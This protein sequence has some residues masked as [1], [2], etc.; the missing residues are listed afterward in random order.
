MCKLCLFILNVVHTS[1]ILFP[2]QL[3]AAE[4]R[5]YSC[6]VSPERIPVFILQHQSAIG[7]SSELLKTNIPEPK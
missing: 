5:I 2:K 4:E 3:L 7:E 6:F 1:F